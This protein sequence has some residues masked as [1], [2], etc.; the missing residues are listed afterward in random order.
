MERNAGESWTDSP[1]QTRSM[2]QCIGPITW[3][4]S[5]KAAASGSNCTGR[6]THHRLGILLVFFFLAACGVLAVSAPREHFTLIPNKCSVLQNVLDSLAAD[7][8][9][10]DRKGGDLGQ[11]VLDQLA[12]ADIGTIEKFFRCF[13]FQE[14]TLQDTDRRAGITRLLITFIDIAMAKVPT[15]PG[16]P[17]AFMEM[18]VYVKLICEQKADGT[19]SCSGAYYIE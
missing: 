6:G 15:D 10:P 1:R 19:H 11:S 9:K 7:F 14:G 8:T 4:A 17:A 2:Q 12:A 3:R 5:R 13:R 16:N 18:P